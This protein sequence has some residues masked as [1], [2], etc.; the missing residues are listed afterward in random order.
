MNLIARGNM[1]LAGKLKPVDF[2]ADFP[3]FHLLS[4]PM[5]LPYI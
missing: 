4:T 1:Q 2:Q 3:H 5:N